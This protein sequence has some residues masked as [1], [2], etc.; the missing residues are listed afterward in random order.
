MYRGVDMKKGF[1]LV[2]LLIAI[3]VMVV[4]FTILA[5]ITYDLTTK[6]QIVI[7]RLN[8]ISNVNFVNLRII[9]NV[10]KAGPEPNRF[11]TV[12][13]SSIRYEVIVPFSIYGHITEQLTVKSSQIVLQQKPFSSYDFT[14][15]CSPTFNYSVEIPFK[16]DISANFQGMSLGKL[17][18]DLSVKVPVKDIDY[19]ANIS[20]I[21][22]K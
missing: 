17:N 22:I 7:E 11:Q 14:P 19:K 20:L 10:Q 18:Y 6:S 15:S 1:T 8:A 13:S 9:Q 4:T 16:G 5:I 21:N 3:V 2:E 12:N